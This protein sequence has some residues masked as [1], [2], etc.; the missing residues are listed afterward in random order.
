MADF[1]ATLPSGAYGFPRGSQAQAST[2]IAR[3]GWLETGATG[4]LRPRC[5]RDFVKAYAKMLT[6]V[7]TEL[8]DFTVDVTSRPSPAPPAP[9]S[10]SS[11]RFRCSGSLAI[12]AT[13]PPEIHT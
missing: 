6:Q 9:R 7:A 12:S 5:L 13:T 1:L 2:K 3:V 10:E 11:T 4:H 8:I